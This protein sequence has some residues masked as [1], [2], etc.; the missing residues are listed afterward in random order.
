MRS[1]F[2]SL[3][4][5]AGACRSDRPDRSL[6]TSVNFFGWV[7]KGAPIAKTDVPRCRDAEREL[8]DH[9]L[10]LAVVKARVCFPGQ[11]EPLLW[12]RALRPY[13]RFGS[14][15]DAAR[16]M[17]D[18][19]NAWTGS[20]GQPEAFPWTWQAPPPPMTGPGAS[21]LAAYKQRCISERSDF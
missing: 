14:N 18:F 16:V 2:I 4:L 20:V 7:C 1:L 13:M 9:V 3:V 17:K 19:A 5:V 12:I 8:A 21:D 11:H 15:K 6:R 10:R